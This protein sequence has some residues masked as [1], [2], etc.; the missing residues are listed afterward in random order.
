MKRYEVVEVGRQVVVR[1]RRWFVNAESEQDAIQQVIQ[2]KAADGYAGERIVPETTER[3]GWRV[4]GN[5]VQFDGDATPRGG[6]DDGERES[7]S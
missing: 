1:E 7:G 5:E 2:R 4:D 3:T 6:H